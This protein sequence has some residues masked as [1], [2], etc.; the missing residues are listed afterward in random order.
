MVE[1]EILKEEEEWR[2]R[3]AIYVPSCAVMYLL[4]DTSFPD[5]K[6]RRKGTGMLN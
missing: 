5:P 6:R 4:V 2:G 3:E 1:G